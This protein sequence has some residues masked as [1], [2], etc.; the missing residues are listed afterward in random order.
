[1]RMPQVA[2]LRCAM[3]I[4]S[5]IALVPLAAVAQPAAGSTDASKPA[6]DVFSSA[7]GCTVDSVNPVA[8]RARTKPATTSSTVATRGD[9]PTTGTTTPT[10]A[11][12]P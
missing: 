10:A 11:A 2:P 8:A 3:T 6:C 1:M 9:A 7:H 12:S 5:L 4:A